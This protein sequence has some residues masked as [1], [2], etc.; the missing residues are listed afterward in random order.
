MEATLENLELVFKFIKD[1][2]IEN[3]SGGADF[4]MFDDETTIV[5]AVKYTVEQLEEGD[6]MCVNCGGGFSHVTFCE[7]RDADFCDDCY[8]R[9][10]LKS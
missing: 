8:N 2:H 7:E 5:D 3:N 10:I 9:P 1:N 6:F 4:A